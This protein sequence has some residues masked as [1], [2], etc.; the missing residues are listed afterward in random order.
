MAQSPSLLRAGGRN[1]SA[2]I[3][4]LSIRATTSFPDQV[5]DVA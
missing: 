3:S 4:P 5:D 1:G 2:D